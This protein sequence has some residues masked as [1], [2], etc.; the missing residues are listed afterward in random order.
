MIYLLDFYYEVFIDY[1]VIIAQFYHNYDK[2]DSLVMQEADAEVA[3][4]EKM[5]LGEEASQEEKQYTLEDIAT[6]NGLSVSE[7]N[8]GYDKDGYINFIGNT[9]CED[10][11][12]DAESAIEALEKVSTL[13][14]LD[15]VSL[16]LIRTDVSPTTKATYYTYSQVISTEENSGNEM[17]LFGNGIVKVIADKDGNAAGVSLYIQ[18]GELMEF[19]A[20]RMFTKEEAE[21][22][23]HELY[24]DAHIYTEATR[25]MYWSD[26]AVAGY[27]G[28]EGNIVPVWIV[29]IDAPSEENGLSLDIA[30]GATLTDGSINCC[31]YLEL[32]IPAVRSKENPNE[33]SIVASYYTN[34]IDNA[35]DIIGNYVP[36]VYPWN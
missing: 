29:Y 5:D 2:E 25:C 34:N 13:L 28:S 1:I 21:Q 36:R 4:E 35:D 7:L 8:V 9:F 27:V 31:P 33:N 22:M 10:K 20:D 6:L 11:I 14:C 3:T 32:V 23:V 30:E 19:D 18:H 12:T 24:E 16:E 17:E 15:E 26:E